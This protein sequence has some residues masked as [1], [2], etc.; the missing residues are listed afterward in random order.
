M[1][2]K[3]FDL[4]NKILQQDINACFDLFEK[5]NFQL[6]NII[7]N[8][9]LE[10]CLIFDDYQLCL[11]G[12]FIKD[13]VNDYVAIINNPEKRKTINSAKVF[14]EKL[15]LKIQDFFSDRNE[16]KLWNDFYKYNLSINEFLREKIDVHYLKNPQFSS[17]SFE[18]LLNYIENHVD[19]LYVINNRFLEG[20]LDIMVRVIRNHDFHLSELTVYIY[21]KFLGFLYPYI[22]Y[23]NYSSGQ[24]LDNEKMKKDLSFYIE[25]LNS[26]KE[27]TEID[28]IDFDKNLWSIVKKWREMY[29][30]YKGLPIE[31]DL[32][33]PV[34]LKRSNNKSKK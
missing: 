11:P 30:F 26:L 15:I 27:K 14:G 8:R 28:I 12:V 10:N 4:A 24:Q 19:Y 21:L 16:E 6:I 20:I 7:A 17:K 2:D 29:I 23:E 31:R 18:F 5:D 33:I 34:G 13:M 1:S 22:Y 25:F 32:L 9:Y 3:S